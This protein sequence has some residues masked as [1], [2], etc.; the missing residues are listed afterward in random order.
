MSSFV[1]RDNLRGGLWLLSD[2]AL[3]IWALS[4]VKA[5]GLGYGAAQLV[6][7]RALVG[8]ILIA[9]LIWRDR[10][11]FRG[12][13]HLRL[14]LLRVALSA[15]TLSLSFFAISR[16]PLAVFTAINFTRPLVTMVMAALILGEVIGRR[17]WRAAGVALIGVLI[18]LNPGDVSWNWGLAALGVV[19]LTGCGAIIVTRHLRSAPEIVL[20]TFYT[21]GLT[22]FTAPVAVAT[23]VPLSPDHLPYLLLIGVF[24]QTAQLCFLRAHYHGEAGFLSVL[25]YLSL[26]LSVAVGYVVF[27]EVPTLSFWAGALLVIAAAL[28]V[29]LNSKPQT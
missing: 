8:L 2:L 1:P 18:A 24:S 25:S 29:S 26:V 6:L 19:V 22:L 4:I 3:N 21:A 23:W 9:P 15:L 16:V 12:I 11:A 28:W 14:H 10:A 17:R 5:L 7:L 13:E 27:D 20:M